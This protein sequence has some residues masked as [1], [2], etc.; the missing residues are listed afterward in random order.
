MTITSIKNV[1]HKGFIK[2]INLAK[3]K[4]LSANTLIRVFEPS[5]NS[6]EEKHNSFLK[7]EIWRL[8]GGVDI[9]GEDQRD[10]L[11]QMTIYSTSADNPIDMSSSYPAGTFDKSEFCKDQA[12]VFAI[13]CITEEL[14][15]PVVLSEIAKTYY[16]TDIDK[17]VIYELRER[18]IYDNQ[19]E[20]DI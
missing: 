7:F 4:K 1:D 3:T 17:D 11:D 2:L 14:A 8:E 19:F 16:K 13:D 5:T 18:D 6:A 10:V 12:N 9:F 15:L 20:L